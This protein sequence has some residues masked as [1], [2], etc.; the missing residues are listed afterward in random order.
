MAPPR[1]RRPGFSRRAQYG[2]FIGYVIA[3]FGA[4]IALVFLLLS[5]FNP[6][7]FSTARGAAREV[8]TPLSSGMHAVRGWLGSIPGAIGDHFGTVSENQRL[9]AQLISSRR[10]VQS[11]RTLGR[12]NDRLRKLLQLRDNNPTTVVTAR[13]VSSSSGSTRRYAILNAGSRQGVRESQPVR[14]PNGLIGRIL[15]T[16][17]DTARVLLIIDAESIV[18][19]RR[20]RDGMPAIV[21]GR[22]DGLVDVRA[23]SV[24]NAPFLAGDTFVT[25]G[26]GGIYPPNIPVARVIRNSSDSA[27]ARVF[28]SPDTADFAMVQQVFMPKT[29]QSS[30][31]TGDAVASAPA[32]DT[33]DG[34]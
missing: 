27:L 32:D 5:T 8:T 20:V 21:V 19:V 11:A 26:T 9:R 24:A 6:T 3:V 25:S 10:L 2:L 22:G 17:P 29:A 31:D 18:P 13:L 4:I 14:G 1:N 34:A 30:G 28:A 12:E 15:E 23:A 33:D 7:A 16:G